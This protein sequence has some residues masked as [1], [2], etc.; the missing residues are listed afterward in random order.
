MAIR[1]I[2]TEEDEILRKQCKPVK[3][4]NQRMIDLLDDMADTMYEANGVG[5]AAP[6]VGIL[7]QM[8]VVDVGD[9]LIELINPEIIYTE[10]EQSGYEGCLSVPGKMG[11]VTRPL[12]VKVK[13]TDRKGEEFE[14]EAEELKARALCHEI[15][16]LSGHLYIERVEGEL[17]DAASLNDDEEEEEDV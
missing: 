17:I 2:R 14:I 4:I 11:I 6:Q 15:E 1:K 3:D 12:K 9:G 13:A 5:L 7:R 8:A 10:G 16:H